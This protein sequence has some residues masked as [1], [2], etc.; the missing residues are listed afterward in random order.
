MG[1]V[2]R[3]PKSE[4]ERK[5]YN[6]EYEPGRLRRAAVLAVK[7]MGPKEYAVAGQEEPVYFVNLNI[8]VPCTCMDATM[9]GRGCKHELAARLQT[10]EPALVMA[11]GQ[12][13][14]QAEQRSAAL[15]RTTRRKGKG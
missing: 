3:A 11:L 9:H 12:M 13:L 7:Q 8:D 14:L 4:V 10:G 1:L 2:A 5:H 6:G 15:Q